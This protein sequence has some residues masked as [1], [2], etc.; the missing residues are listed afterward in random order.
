VDSARSEWQGEVTALQAS[1]TTL[2]TAIQQLASNPGTS[3]V[4]AVRTGLQGVG[5]AA[6]NLFAVVGASCPSLS[7]SPTS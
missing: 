7:P 1:L 5:T 3:T 6:R 4:A 2:Q